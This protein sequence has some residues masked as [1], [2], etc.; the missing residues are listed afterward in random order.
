M[1]L[2]SLQ[3]VSAEELH[4]DKEKWTEQLNPILQL[5]QNVFKAQ[6]FRAIKVTQDDLRTPDPVD[7]FV[8]MEM[9]SVKK[10]L[11]FVNESI[12]SI[13]KVLEGTEM[14]TP[15]IQSEATALLKNQ[16]PAAWE[17]QWEGPE[18]PQNWLRILCKKGTQ[19][20]TWVQKTQQK[21]LLSGPICISD[22]LHPETFLNA[23][24]QK[25]ARLNKV[26]IDELKLV[27]SF[28]P[29]KIQANGAI[30]VEG[31][32]LQGCAFD[33][34]R[35]NEI[36]GKASEVVQLPICTLAWISEGEA[37]PYSQGVV[38]TPI[39]FNLDREK[40]LCTLKMAANGDP[41]NYIISG[42]ALF[43][44]GSD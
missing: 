44:N 38:E 10:I 16:V 18:N 41:S 28:E 19:L 24:R 2:K 5:W 25:S 21:Q 36:R 15:K 23:F 29:G 42:V 13:I 9:I 31:L 32:W 6:I 40:L 20:V 22:L 1:Q 26:A 39:Y 11:A 43:L 7:Q 35:M 8:F 4:F 14:L 37:D 17:K 33:G 12:V 3:A 34:A 30:Q 27:S